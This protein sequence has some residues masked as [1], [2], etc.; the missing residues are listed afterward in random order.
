MP[1]VTREIL[2][3]RNRAFADCLRP[4]HPLAGRTLLEIGAAEGANVPYFL[5]MGFHPKHLVLN[6]L[7]ADKI[8]R[9]RER[10]P[11]V[12]A[13]AGDAATLS[14]DEPFDVVVASTVFTS[15]PVA[16]R[17]HVAATMWRLVKPGGGVL[18]YDF[19]WNNPRNPHVRKLTRREIRALFPEAVIRWQRVTLAPPLSRHVPLGVYRVLARVPWLR[20]HVV[21]W[22]AKPNGGAPAMSLLTCL[23]HHLR[24][25][26]L[27]QRYRAL[28]EVDREAYGALADKHPPS[29]RC[30]RCRP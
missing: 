22:L 4:L 12:R 24:C 29:V 26:A 7:V 30:R 14:A 3:E 23:L 9:A 19:T 21:C 5:A 28:E 8:T 10:F 1:D 27:H 20:T 2:A 15:V 11:D 18:L 17:P 6:D 16:H 25:V 13:V